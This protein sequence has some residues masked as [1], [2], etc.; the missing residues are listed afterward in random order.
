MRTLKK[1]V[2]NHSATAAA[3]HMWTSLVLLLTDISIHFRGS[4]YLVSSLCE[5][6]VRHC[7]SESQT[8]ELKR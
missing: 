3:L 2:R 8:R 4:N 6:L 7:A 1:L 5:T